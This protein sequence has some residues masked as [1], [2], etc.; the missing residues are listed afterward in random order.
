MLYLKRVYRLK[1]VDLDRE[2]LSEY[3]QQLQKIG[4]NY[5]GAEAA[6][7]FAANNSSLEVLSRLGGGGGSSTGNGLAQPSS[8]SVGF[9]NNGNGNGG[10][11]S[12]GR[13][14][15]SAIA[16]VFSQLD[17]DSN[18]RLSQDEARQLYLRLS[19]R[20]GRSQS[21]D[22]ARQFVRSLAALSGSDGS[23]SLSEFRRAFERLI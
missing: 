23:I 18:G 20:L 9:N 12:S 8:Y 16:D 11:S 19:S 7:D 6:R 5:I 4:V 15:V 21:D 10:Y 3:R 17:R 2:G 14:S 22:D 1:L 13:G